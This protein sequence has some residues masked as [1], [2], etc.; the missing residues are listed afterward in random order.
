MAVRAYDRALNSCRNWLD[1]LTDK[2]EA[3]SRLA[4]LAAILIRAIVAVN[5]FSAVWVALLDTSVP[6]ET[7]KKKHI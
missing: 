7:Q 6:A 4:K 5:L 2:A 3:A 1:V